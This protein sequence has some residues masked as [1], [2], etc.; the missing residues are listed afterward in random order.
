VTFEL[1]AAEQISDLRGE[2]Q[3]DGAFSN[4]G[5][6]NCIPDLQPVAAG[7]GS[8]LRPGAKL[9]VCLMGRFCM[10]ESAWYLLH[11]RLG[12]AFR[13]LR[14]GPEGIESSLGSESRVRVYYHSVAELAASFR[15]EF[16]LIG[17]RGV[18]IFVPPSYLE[19]WARGKPSFFR[20]LSLLDERLARW[21]TLRGAADHRLAVFLRR[22]EAP[23]RH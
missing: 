4:F 16:S 15:R 2:G 21:P 20:R 22:G 10:W 13:R 23:C 19:S 6:L 7:L 1:R 11:A 8:L 14:A 17:Y 3:F 9:I 12:K 5:V 18:G